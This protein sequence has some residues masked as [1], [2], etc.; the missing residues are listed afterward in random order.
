MTRKPLETFA[1][2]SRIFHRERKWF[3]MAGSGVPAG[4]FDNLRITKEGGLKQFGDFVILDKCLDKFF[5]MTTD[6]GDVKRRECVGHMKRIVASFILAT[7]QESGYVIVRSQKPCETEETFK[8]RWHSDGRYLTED[9][10]VEYKMVI[11]MNGRGT[12]VSVPNEEQM[13]EII[14]MDKMICRLG[15]DGKKKESKEWKSKLD[16]YM[17]GVK[18]MFAEDCTKGAVYQ[19]WR[20]RGLVHSLHSEPVF[21]RFRIFMSVVAG[22]VE[23]LQRYMDSHG[24]KQ[25]VY[26]EGA[27]VEV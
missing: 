21:D 11:A 25:M 27:E 7:G 2:R 4:H 12:L 16:R 6:M 14:K 5:R 9:D 3:E 17:E 23:G 26:I 22:S 20:D 19:V 18:E 13:K 8:P 24:A 15:W 10:G 1:S